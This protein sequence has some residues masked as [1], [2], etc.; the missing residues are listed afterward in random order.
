MKHRDEK[1]Y[2]LDIA[3]TRSTERFLDSSC[4]KEHGDAKIGVSMAELQPLLNHCKLFMHEMRF[5]TKFYN[6]LYCKF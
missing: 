6:A 4:D 3:N 2:R 1:L 5:Y